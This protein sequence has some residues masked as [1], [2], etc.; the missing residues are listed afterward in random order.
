MK[1]M[2]AEEIQ[3]MVQSMVIGNR[4]VDGVDWQLAHRYC[5]AA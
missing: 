3:L 2:P 4:K 5:S 1:A